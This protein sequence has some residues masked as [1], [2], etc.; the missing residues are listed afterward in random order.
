MDRV[1]AAMVEVVGLEEG[2]SVC[3]C[4]SCVCEV[5][6]DAG[7]LYLAPGLCC[8]QRRLPGP[9]F[10]VGVDSWQQ[11]PLISAGVVFTIVFTH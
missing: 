6:G 4:M 2:L 3:E 9:P 1:E 5:L 8:P 10:L 11:E 7:L